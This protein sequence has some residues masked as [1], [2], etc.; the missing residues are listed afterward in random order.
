[1]GTTPV[2]KIAPAEMSN[3]EV[4]GLHKYMGSSLIV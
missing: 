1:V 3:S 4:V 2:S